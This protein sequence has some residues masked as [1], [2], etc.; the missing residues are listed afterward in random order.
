MRKRLLGCRSG[1]HESKD[2]IPGR[3]VIR[4]LPYGTIVRGV[5]THRHECYT[6]TNRQLSSK[7]GCAVTR[8]QRI[9]KPRGCKACLAHIY[10]EF[11]LVPKFYLLALYKSVGGSSF[12]H[13]CRNPASKDGKLW[14]TTDALVSTDG[15]LRL[16]KL[17][18]SSTCTT[19]WLP[20][21]A[22]ISASLPE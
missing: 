21:M 1:C 17:P 16:G 14:D 18:G 3:D 5:D 12:R 4:G 8:H 7:P 22:W 10:K 2:N 15:K 6:H 9:A 20:S 11:V 13:G 19:D